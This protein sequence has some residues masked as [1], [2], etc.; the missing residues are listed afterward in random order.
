MK[1]RVRAIFRRSAIRLRRTIHSLS[2]GA[3]IFR[4]VVENSRR[5]LIFRKNALLDLP[6]VSICVERTVR[7]R[8]SVGST[9]RSPYFLFFDPLYPFRRR[10]RSR[11]RHLFHLGFPPIVSRLSS[12]LVFRQ[13]RFSCRALHLA[14]VVSNLTIFLVKYVTRRSFGDINRRLRQYV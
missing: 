13:F 8:E 14:A 1:S 9:R 12:I 11:P 3:A 2:V 7:F 10:R 6:V 5:N 4:V